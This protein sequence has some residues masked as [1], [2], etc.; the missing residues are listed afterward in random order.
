MK[1]KFIS[2]DGEWPNLCRGTL[3]LEINEK[4]WIFDSYYKKPEIDE[5][6]NIHSSKFWES[7]GSAGVDFSGEISEAYCTGG[8]WILDKEEIPNELKNMSQE[9]ID[10]FNENVPQGCCGGCI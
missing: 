3:K 1:I 10:I 5:E 2:Y 9:L 8:P 7:G 4:L 6:G